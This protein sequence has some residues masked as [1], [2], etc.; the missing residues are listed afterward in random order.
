M[1]LDEDIVLSKDFINLFL[2]SKVIAVPDFWYVVDN[3]IQD[4]AY[5][6]SIEWWVFTVS[7]LVAST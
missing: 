6:I 1:F 4:F 7:G 5:R 3:W 2:V